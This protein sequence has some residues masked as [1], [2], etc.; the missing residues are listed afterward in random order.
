MFKMNDNLMK[1]F[2][3]NL[4]QAHERCLSLTNHLCQSNLGNS[5]TRFDA[6]DGYDLDISDLRGLNTLGEHGCWA[7]IIKLLNHIA[8]TVQTSEYVHI[9][10]DDFRF[11]SDGA[12]CISHLPDFLN[13]NN[14]QHHDIVFLDYFLGIELYRDIAVCLDQAAL[15]PD[16]SSFEFI[17]GNNYLACTSS[18][19]VRASSAEFIARLLQ[20]IY[21]HAEVLVPIDIALRSLIR[22]GALNALLLMPLFGT[23]DYAHSSSSQIQDT[24][25]SQLKRSRDAH[26]LLRCAA[27]QLYT[28]QITALKLAD[29]FQ[30]TINK[31]DYTTYESICF[32]W[33]ELER[34]LVSF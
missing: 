20:N 17:P 25:N 28:P 30:I 7:S 22:M 21:S 14:K 34:Y 18:F 6:V 26:L 2:F 24:S 13:I 11:N 31:N 19:L 33:H 16:R 3:I 10:E 5:Y 12:Q 9:I 4:T 29:L 32:L 8:N 23:S 15:K 27:A 1:G